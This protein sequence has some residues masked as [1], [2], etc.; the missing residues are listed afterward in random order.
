MKSM[1][2]AFMFLASSL[3][4]CEQN[5]VKP[6]DVPAAVRQ[7]LLN[8]F[9]NT[10]NLEWEKKGENYEAEFD[11]A[12]VE[13]T[14]LLDAKGSLLQHKY[15]ITEAELPEAVKAAISQQYADYILDDADVLVKGTT[16]FYQVELEKG[17]QEEKLV[18]AADGSQ[19]QEAYWD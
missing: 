9:P 6:E 10:S 2:F 7:T 3:F 18:F 1:L 13:H 19:S 12:T 17:M 5:D 14:A 8:V 15:D 11:V 4:A 16:S